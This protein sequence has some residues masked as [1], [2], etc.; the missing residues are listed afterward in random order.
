M[1]FTGDLIQTENELR[2]AVML[3]LPAQPLCSEQ[4]QGLCPQ[5][6]KNLNE[7]ACDCD[8]SALE[9]SAWKSALQEIKLKSE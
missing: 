5:C 4:C 3:D 7:G 9:I 1:P 6:G 2:E 8:K